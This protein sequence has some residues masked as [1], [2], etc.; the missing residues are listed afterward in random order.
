MIV[1]LYQGD[2]FQT[3]KGQYQDNIMAQWLHLITSDTLSAQTMLPDNWEFD[4][5]DNKIEHFICPYVE[6]AID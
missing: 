6:W 3:E 2:L 5:D 4:C 1:M